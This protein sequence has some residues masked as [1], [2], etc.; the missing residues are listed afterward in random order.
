MRHG[1][2]G[3]FLF[4]DRGPRMVETYASD[5][6]PE[7]KTRL[8]IFVKDMGIVTGIAKDAH[9][10]VPLASAAQQLYLLGEA[11]AW[12]PTTTPRSSP[13]CPPADSLWSPWRWGRAV[14][15]SGTSTTRAMNVHQA[16]RPGRGGRTAHLD[17]PHHGHGRHRVRPEGRRPALRPAE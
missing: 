9:V 2:A 1:A 6:A 16:R 15:P 13:T 17:G 4:G 5:V 14:S 3:S 12:P 11:A 8:D 10:P 7:V